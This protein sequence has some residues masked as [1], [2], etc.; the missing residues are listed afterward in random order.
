MYISRTMGKSKTIVGGMALFAGVVSILLIVIPSL[1]LQQFLGGFKD[2]LLSLIFGIMG[3]VMAAAQFEA[4]KGKAAQAALICNITGI[5]LAVT[6]GIII[7]V[8]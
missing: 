4:Y 1:G 6:K 5:V 3:L 7:I 8:R 2:I